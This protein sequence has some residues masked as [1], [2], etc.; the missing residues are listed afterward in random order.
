M[1]RILL[2]ILALAAF[3][4]LESAEAKRPPAVPKPGRV[5]ICHRTASGAHPYVRIRVSTRAA[6]QGHLRHAAD[7]VPAP[8]AGCPTV[9][10]TPTS[11]G[12]VLT[13]TLSGANEVPPADPDG[14]GTATF[15]LIRGSAVICYRL[16]VSNITLPATGAHI[17]LGAAGTNGPIV[18]PL[19]PPN[20]SG[21]SSGCTTTTR[22]LV[23]AILDNPAG[24]YANVHTTD[25]PSGA[26]RGQLSA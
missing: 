6:D 11:G 1:R 14:S 23:A 17:H 19:T 25:Y 10:L 15:R 9:P 5:T 2:G 7:V 16:T 24:Y 22:A 12:V 4:G 3:V 20:A 18:V 21:S 13:A 8:A 26:I